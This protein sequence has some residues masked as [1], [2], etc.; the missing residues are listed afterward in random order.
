MKE[1]IERYLRVRRF[2]FL[3]LTSPDKEA[4]QQRGPSEDHS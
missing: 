4:M 2:S 3:L 1:K